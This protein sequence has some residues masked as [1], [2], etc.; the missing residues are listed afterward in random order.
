MDPTYVSSDDEADAMAAAMGFSSFGTQGPAK[1][2]K[3]NPKTD[4]TIDGE[5]ASL[6]KGGKNGQGS[7][8]NTI[9]L[10]K[11]RVLG[12]SAVE[13]N[14]DEI[15][16]DEEMEDE[17]PAYID[18]SQPP[19]DQAAQEAQQKIDAILAASQGPEVEV[20][21]KVPHAPKP[22]PGIGQYM[23]ALHNQQQS[24]P[25][26][27]PPQQLFMD[28]TTSVASSHQ[29]RGRERNESWFVGYFDPS[30]IQNPWARL[31]EAKGLQPRGTWSE[32]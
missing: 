2:R 30:S 28:N 16:L 15:M 13:Q 22:G 26:R 18:T 5:L 1:K 9:P 8:G 31:E 7:G 27:P 29:S 4:A 23:A 32:R 11:S 6:D 12:V 14:A 19:P 17:E 24:L 20:S 3:F 21:G 25:A 10:G